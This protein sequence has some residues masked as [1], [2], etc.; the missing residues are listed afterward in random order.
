MVETGGVDSAEASAAGMPLAATAVLAQ[1]IAAGDAVAFGHFYD[2]WFESACR[3]VRTVSRRDESFCLDVVHDAMLRVVK[4]IRGLRDEAAVHRWMVQTLTSTAIDR[5]RSEQ[6]RARRE[7]RWAEAT[8]S[9]VADPVAL[10][11][12]AERADWVQCRLAELEP[13]E[14]QLLVARFGRDET[15]ERVGQGCGISGDAAH[16]RIRRILTRLREAAGQW[17]P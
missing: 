17:M 6:R 1:R 13:D 10:A 15:L 16:G 7:S 3:I 2:L 8:D 12:A 14:R 11:E 9:S 4:S 5:L